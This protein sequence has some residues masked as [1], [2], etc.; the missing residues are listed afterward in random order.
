MAAAALPVFM[1]ASLLQSAGQVSA[2]E[3]ARA[4]SRVEAESIELGAVQREADRKSD[5][6]RAM[7]SQTASA[8]SRGIATFE[9]SPLSVL[10][11]DIEAEEE[12][13]QRDLFQS[14]L[15]AKTA[16]A[17]GKAQRSQARWN[18]GL[19]LLSS[20]ATAAM[21]APTKT[22]VANIVSPSGFTPM[23]G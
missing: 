4:Q 17:K 10:Q 13:T 12:A 3:A 2:G 7:A 1:G 21:L 5:L 9:G 19:G 14:D 18:A 8:G 11:T 20:G 15:A 6:A 23:G 22:P 16:L